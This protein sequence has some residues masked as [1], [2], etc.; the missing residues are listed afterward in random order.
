VIPEQVLANAPLHRHTSLRVGGPARFLAEPSDARILASSLRWVTAEGIEWVCLGAGTNVVFPDSGFPGVVVHAVGLRGIRIDGVRLAAAAGE[1]LSWAARL[2]CEAGLS[3]MEWAWGI[4]GSVGGAVAMNAGAQGGETADALV[5]VETATADG[6]NRRRAH[7]LGFGYRRSMFLT[8]KPREVVTEA[9]FELAVSTPERTVA[10][11]R[12]LLAERGRKFPSGAT[13]G[14]TFRNPP[15]GPSAGELL[16]KAGCK[17][18]R[19]GSAWVSDVHANF[20]INDGSEN[21]ADVLELIE[22]MKRR[23]RDACG[24]GLI[25]EI[26]VYP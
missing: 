12:R 10:R 22:A 3:G 5:D 16:D 19:V 25:E 18:L 4:P 15:E 7:D 8:E 14:C 17:G 23:V 26:V 11:A 21:A 6:L 20:I 24:V 1:P 2:A 13:A 9:T